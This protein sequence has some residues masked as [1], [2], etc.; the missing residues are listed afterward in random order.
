MFCDGRTLEKRATG[1]LSWIEQ[2]EHVSKVAMLKLSV[3]ERGT[4]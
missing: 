1:R 3:Q 2:G 4:E